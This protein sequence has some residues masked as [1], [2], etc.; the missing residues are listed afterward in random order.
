MQPKTHTIEIFKKEFERQQAEN[1][2]AH[3]YHSFSIFVVKAW[4]REY[5]Q[6]ANE[7]RTFFEQFGNIF[8]R[9]QTK[10]TDAD[11]RHRFSILV[12]N[13]RQREYL[14]LADDQ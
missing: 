8:G 3:A 2:D 14:K 7:Q 12:V 9:Q 6:L 5:L 11:A 1:I 13:A 10:N 4:R